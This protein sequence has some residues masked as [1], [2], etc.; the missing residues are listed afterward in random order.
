MTQSVLKRFPFA[1]PLSA[2]WKMYCA[3]SHDKARQRGRRKGVSARWVDDKFATWKSLKLFANYLLFSGKLS[4]WLSRWRPWPVR[5]SVLP[6]CE[7]ISICC[8]WRFDCVKGKQNSQMEFG[9][10][11][12]SFCCAK[13]ID[14]LSE[15]I[16]LINYF[17][18]ESIL[19]KYLGEQCKRNSF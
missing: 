6:S 12:G 5:P 3:G 16:I 10:K 18:I 1:L 8:W 15:K 4:H 11:C 19:K 2:A 14:L 9:V 7:T 17:N 13:N